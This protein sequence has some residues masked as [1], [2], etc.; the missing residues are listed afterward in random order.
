[1]VLSC[2]YVVPSASAYASGTCDLMP[3]AAIIRNGCGAGAEEVCE[4]S[5]SAMPEKQAALRSNAARL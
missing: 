1:M 3:R 2:S 5:M 4:D